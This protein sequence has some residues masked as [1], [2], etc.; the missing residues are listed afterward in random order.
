MAKRFSPEEQ[1]Q[2]R[3][4]FKNYD[5]DASGAIDKSE[6]QQALKDMGHDDMTEEKLQAMFNVVD[7]NHDGVIDWSEFLKMMEHLK[8]QG[9][10]RKSQSIN[11]KG[12]SA[13]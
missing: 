11:L 10:K 2:L 6:F 5:R 8:I 7:L 13:A 12:L 1:T 4:T 3:N 9:T